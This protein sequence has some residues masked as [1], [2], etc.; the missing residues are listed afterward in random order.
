[1]ADEWRD[2]DYLRGREVAVSGGVQAVS[3]VAH[4][5]GA[6]GALLVKGPDGLTAVLGGEVTLRTET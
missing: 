6:D 3:G 5:V 1:M 2:H 4:G